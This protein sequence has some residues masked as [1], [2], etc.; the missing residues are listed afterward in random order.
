[1]AQ[2]RKV[3]PEVSSQTDTIVKTYKPQLILPFRFGIVESGLF[4]GAYPTSKNH[5]FLKRLACLA[6][7]MVCATRTITHIMFHT[8]QIEAQNHD[9]VNRIRTARVV[10]GIL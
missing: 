5:R 10:S 7:Y 8:S 6:I 4:R 1:M 9:I 2:D 3:Q